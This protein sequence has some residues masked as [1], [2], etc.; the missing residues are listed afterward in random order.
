MRKGQELEIEP[1]K[2]LIVDDDDVSVMKVKRTISK[3]EFSNPI[4]VARDGVEALE[5]LRG[6]NGKD[7]LSPPYIVT[8]DINMPRMDGHEF[9]RELRGDPSLK[10]TV[11]FVL[12]TSDNKVDIDCAYDQ[13]VTGYIVK[14]RSEENLHDAIAMIERFSSLVM[15]PG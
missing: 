11:V 1:V 9:L 15:L 10:N 12:T 14:E 8:L 2:F 7:R 3:A 5:I 4:F 13:H 6:N